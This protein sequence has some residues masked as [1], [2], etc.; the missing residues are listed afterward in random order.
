MS[1][2]LGTIENYSK[3]AVQAKRLP[4]ESLPEPV[5]PAAGFRVGWA[6]S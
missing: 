6:A 4:S 1:F 2:D 3:A 5:V